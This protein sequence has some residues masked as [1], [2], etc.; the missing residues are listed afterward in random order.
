MLLFQR[1]SLFPADDDKG[2]DLSADALL[3]LVA[4]ETFRAD[5]SSEGEPA[6]EDGGA[7]KRC[8]Q[9]DG[10]E[11]ADGHQQCGR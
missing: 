10:E 6:E 7:A 2:V 8:Q 3:F 5:S 11:A 9:T 1:C 4:P